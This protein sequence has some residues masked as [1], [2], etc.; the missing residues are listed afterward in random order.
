[1]KSHHHGP[2]EGVFAC[3][4][5]RDVNII[6][7]TDGRERGEDQYKGEDDETGEK[8]ERGLLGGWQ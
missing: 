5:L 1:M 8:R 4:K 2:R 3:D 6:P 7:G